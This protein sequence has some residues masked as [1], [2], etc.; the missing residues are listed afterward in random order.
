MVGASDFVRSGVSGSGR[1]P[2]LMT[3]RSF[4]FRSRSGTA[5]VLGG[6]CLALA[7]GNVLP[8]T[9]LQSAGAAAPAEG[10]PAIR[11]PRETVRLF[12]Q[13]IRRGRSRDAFALTTRTSA[14][15]WSPEFPKLREYDRI[16]PRHQLGTDQ[17]ALV[18]SNPFRRRTGSEVFYAALVKSDG[19][20]LIHRSGCATP[21]EA[22]WMMRG[23]QSNP[24][25]EVEALPEE[26]VGVWWAVCDSTIVL[27]PDGTGH[28]LRVGPGGPIP[29]EEPEAFKWEVTGHELHRHF[30]NR[31]ETLEITWIDDNSIRFHQTAESPWTHWERRERAAQAGARPEHAVGR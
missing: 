26:L 12:L 5:R 19:H 7:F 9:A 8:Q 17:H 31:R 21:T 18:V 20:W 30:G 13:H 25:V 27:C 2:T 11:S 28:E 15:S 10:L 3:W 14:T 16:R 4:G 23:Y 1:R 29:G 22:T 6:M 24:A